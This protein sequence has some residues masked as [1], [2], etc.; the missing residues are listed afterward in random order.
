[1]NA[2]FAPLSITGYATGIHADVPADVYH[3][4]ELGVVNKGALDQLA[5]TP[6]H[7]RAW[8][9]GVDQKETP[10]MLFGRA[11]HALVL[12]PDTFARHFK[13][14]PSFGDLRTKAGRE[15]RDDWHMLNRGVQ[16]VPADDMDR[17]LAMRDAVMAHP[18]AS[19]L[20]TGGQA[21]ETVVWTDPVHGL[22]CKAR[23]DYHQRQ[24]GIVVDLKSTEDASPQGFALSVVSYRYHVQHAHYSSA[25]A[26]TGN[27]LQA[28]LFV[29][30]E[31]Q[32]PYAVSVYALDP[33]AEAR[34]MD[35]R[36]RDMETLVEC[37]KTDTWPGYPA[38]INRLALPAWAMRD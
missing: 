36:D 13:P 20:F 26:A 6:R 14:A 37:L 19:K 25:F 32:A 15:A 7:Y 18:I 3:R 2:Q 10:A 38:G 12:E 1:M 35:L 28:F 17:M 27:E 11:L 34:G 21:E 30:V 9:S 33:E 5:K 23:M 29:A 31:K 8:I 16:M 22:L 4:R 24:R